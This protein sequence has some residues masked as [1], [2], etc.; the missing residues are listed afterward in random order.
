MLIDKA[1]VLAT[2]FKRLRRLQ[3]SSLSN[4]DLCRL[5][6]IAGRIYLIRVSYLRRSRMLRL[7][8][9][10]LDKLISNHFVVKIVVVD[11]HDLANRSFKQVTSISVHQ[12]V[13]G[14]RG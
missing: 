14:T 13:K 12:F 7:L 2:H 1:A 9:V 4:Y 8:Q 5:V 6:P 10:F 3:A 11:S